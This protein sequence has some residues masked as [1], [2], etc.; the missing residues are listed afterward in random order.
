MCIIFTKFTSLLTQFTR[1]GQSYKRL[2]SISREY[3]SVLRCTFFDIQTSSMG[4][5]CMSNE[6]CCRQ[7]ASCKLQLQLK[8]FNIVQITHK[9]LISCSCYLKSIWDSIKR[10][11][12]KFL[13][14][15]KWRFWE[16]KM[17]F[18]IGCDGEYWRLEPKKK[19]WSKSKEFRIFFCISSKNLFICSSNSSRNVAKKGSS[20]IRFMQMGQWN[21]FVIRTMK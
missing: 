9:K 14:K 19:M 10:R 1:I 18:F 11:K 8:T 21:S 20:I 4:C 15:Y 3:R 12:K 16:R 13:L 6:L 7:P 5:C 17:L 2:L